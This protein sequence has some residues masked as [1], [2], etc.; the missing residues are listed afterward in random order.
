M[1]IDLNKRFKDY[2][3]Q[4]SE[5]IVADRVAEAMFSAGVIQ[6]MDIKREEKFRAYKIC[7]EISIGNGIIDLSSEDITLIKKICSVVFVA[8]FY[9]QICDILE[10][11]ES[12]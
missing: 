12:I 6:E 11:N 10:N 8:G 3:C 1:K 2:K 5:F 9:G 4:D 7:N